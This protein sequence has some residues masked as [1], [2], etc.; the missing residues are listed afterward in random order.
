MNGKRRKPGE[1]EEG[2]RIRSATPPHG[3]LPMLGPKSGPNA[4]ANGAEETIGGASAG[5]LGS[6]PMSPSWVQDDASGQTG[7]VE[8][9]VVTAEWVDKPK[10]TGQR[11][12]G[13]DA[14]G[15]ETTTFEE[16]T[17]VEPGTTGPRK[18][19][20]D[21]E[22][23]RKVGQGGM[24][25]VWLARQVS[26]DRPVAVKVLPRSLANQENFIERF[27]REAK[28]AAS[29]VHPNVLQ[30]YSF[31]VAEGTPYFAMEYVE[32]EDLQ[33]RMR[34]SRGLGWDEIGGI[35]LGVG[36]ALAAA[37]QKGLIHRDIKPSNIMIDRQGVVK[38]MDFGLA[39]AT[40]G[41]NKS[42]TSAGLIMGTPNYLSPE[43]GRGDPL[44]GRSDLYSLGVVLYELLTGQLPFR[45]D[46]PAGLIFK[47]VY[48][49]PPPPLDLN[50]DIPPFLVEV[51]LKLLQKDPDD[52]YKSAQELI[53]DVS[54][55]LEHY[56]HYVQG[57]ERRPGSGY[58][59]QARVG[60]SGG[61]LSG[62]AV[63]RSGAQPPAAPD[64]RH[65]V[66][67]GIARDGGAEPGPSPETDEDAGA[68]RR[69]PAERRRAPPP[70]KRSAAPL[71][72]VLGLV[73]LALGGAWA[74][75]YRPEWL[76]ALGI[77]PTTTGAG[78]QGGPGPGVVERPSP[79]DPA[80]EVPFVLPAPSPLPPRT[81]AT[82]VSTLRVR[83][84]LEPG[85]EGLYPVGDYRLE[86]TRP[87]YEP[88]SLPVRL[89][90]AEDGRGVLV[91][92]QGGD[93]LRVSH[94]WQPSAELVQ[95]YRQGKS[96]LEQDDLAE[97]TREL[98]AAA[99]VDAGFRPAPEDPTVAELL[100][101]AKA[102]VREVEQSAA[103]LGERFE[104]A[105]Q[106]VAER[107]WRSAQQVLSSLGEAQQTDA[108]KALLAQCTTAIA[109]GDTIVA[110]VEQAIQGGA[111][112]EAGQRLAELERADPEHPRMTAL[113]ER[114]E[115]ARG[116]RAQA[117]VEP[118]GE[119]ELA[120]AI[121]RLRAYRDRFGKGDREVERRLEALEGRLTAQ[122]AL[123]VELAALERLAAEGSWAEARVK[124]NQILKDRPDEEKAQRVRA[125]AE[126][127]LA[128][129]AV[130]LAV[131]D[132]DAALTAGG[133]PDDL[134][135]RLDPASP[136]YALERR[137]LVDLAELGARVVESKHEELHTEINGDFAQV[138]A[139]W[140]FRI[141]ML[142]EPPTELV[143][144]H[145]LSLRRTSV[146]GWLFVELRVEGDVRA[147]R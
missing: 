82:L 10:A 122:Q 87:G 71:L 118:R 50:A 5:A 4:G 39:K 136:A 121:G 65:A 70:Q 92:A 140:R 105:R 125:R 21:F 131:R 26:L 37:H 54:E 78:T 129:A 52:R 126:T 56:D 67:E 88:I 124:A 57:G 60:K 79:R 66:T 16:A 130:E 77:A 17:L 141:E 8:A 117:L 48:E 134:L 47:H 42:L 49:P 73:A 45:A 32:G 86:L 19:L 100:E 7:W 76:A 98:E 2:A 63:R 55:F 91:D 81:T 109:R 80:V 143:A 94:A 112:D 44:D 95:A 97:A 144:R 142:G 128:K 18:L 74:A 119:A 40:T 1:D 147:K 90:R 139:T 93:A 30:I 23:E 62:G 138:T 72:L 68:A 58:L 75:K 53:A 12:V 113:Q 114:V 111:L 115:E 108:W 25:E 11:W 104:V 3:Q 146:G 107:R 24:G 96:R 51:T 110:S 29:L 38:V 31:G 120:A 9:E 123:G 84:Q 20:G 137:A 69:A 43:Q 15:E 85:A 135:R 64:V 36:S 6:G 106:H 13:K 28:A 89:A 61:F 127:E 41:G 133:P 59:D 145:R 83:H 22:L 132:L 116:L 27:Q 99:R 33:E 102:R 101:R 14:S 34:R 46:T 103:R 35:L